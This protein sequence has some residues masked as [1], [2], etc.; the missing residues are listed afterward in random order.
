MKPERWQQVEQLYH[1]TLEKAVGERAAFLADA[2]AE[3][4][5]LRREVE[6]LLAYEDRAED[7]IESPALDV[8]AKIFADYQGS[9]MSGKDNQSV[10]SYLAAW[11][12]GDGRSLP[13]GGHALRAP[14]CA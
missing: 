8:A 11:V 5:G 2:C 7:F 4:E 10:Q 13:R 12:G 14:S 6:S 9:T 1:S 3:D